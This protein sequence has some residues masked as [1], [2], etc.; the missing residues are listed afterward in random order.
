MQTILLER[1]LKLAS[2]NVHYTSMEKK[3]GKHFRNSGVAYDLGGRSKALL[4]ASQVM[5]VLKN[6]V[7]LLITV[8]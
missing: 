7:R 5:T 6:K 2:E 4:L 8:T 3:P 1:P